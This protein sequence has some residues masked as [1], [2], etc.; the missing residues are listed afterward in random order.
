MEKVAP[1]PNTLSTARPLQNTPPPAAAPHENRGLSTPPIFE[2]CNL[3][4][5]DDRNIATLKYL[6]SLFAYQ[7]KKDGTSIFSKLM[8]YAY[9]PLG[10]ALV[11]LRLLVFLPI[12]GIFAS[13]ICIPR[14]LQTYILRLELFLF[15]GFWI[16]VKG[17][18]KKEA[19]IW[20]SNHISE[21]DA[22]CLRAI[23]DPHILGYS[24]YATL[25][26]LKCSPLSIMKL[27][28][29]QQQSRTEGNAEARN[30]I[31]DKI[32][33]IIAEDESNKILVF[34]EGGLTN[35]NSGILQFHKFMFGLGETIQPIVLRN[36]TPCPLHLDTGIA[37]FFSNVVTFFFTPFQRYTVE[38]LDATTINSEAGEDALDFAR[39]TAQDIAD[40][41]EV[42]NSLFIISI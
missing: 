16:T 10:V 42:C 1:G 26:W 25:W 18:P 27:V 40:R 2:G 39:R 14:C 24:F 32:K 31:N 28:Y 3:P 9:F 37:S 6:D 23:D 11:F 19:K 13:I 7:R 30:E 4:D 17:R 35:T 38:F 5:L 20:V 15:F 34:P 12:T 41:L 21:I 29:V 8:L 22:L 33:A 36:S